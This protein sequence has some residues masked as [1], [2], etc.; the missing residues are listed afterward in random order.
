VKHLL[1]ERL[2]KLAGLLTEQDTDKDIVGPCTNKT[3]FDLSTGTIEAILPEWLEWSASLTNTA[4]NPSFTLQGNAAGAL[5]ISYLTATPMLNDPQSNFLNYFFSLSGEAPTQDDAEASGLPSPLC[6]YGYVSEAIM[7]MVVNKQTQE[8]FVFSNFAELISQLQSTSWAPVL[9]GIGGGSLNNVN[10]IPQLVNAIQT[11]NQNE[12]VNIEFDFPSLTV[13][14]C[15]CVWTEMIYGCTNPDACNYDSEANNFEDG[16]TPDFCDYESCVGC[17]DENANN[18]GGS[19]ITTN[20]YADVPYLGDLAG[21]EVECE[22]P[23]GPDRG[24]D[25]LTPDKDVRP[26]RPDR[27]RPQDPIDLSP[28]DRP[29]PYSDQT[30]T[31]GADL[32]TTGY[33]CTATGQCVEYQFNPEDF[34]P[35]FQAPDAPFATLEECIESGCQDPDLCNDFGQSICNPVCEATFDCQECADNFIQSSGVYNVYTGPDMSPSD[36]GSQGPYGSFGPCSSMAMYT[37]SVM[38]RFKK[39]AN[40]KKKK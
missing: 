29:L 22:Y 27:E 38:D 8:P 7:S 5:V 3:L 21:Q 35:G 13:N 16:E 4:N 15:N 14:M 2:K 36:P 25:Y 31:G 9:F 6:P 19:V 24:P 11:L 37:E 20:V 12:T 17:P 30:Q 40:I 33:M 34:D 23:E 10:N 32:I 26:T 39:L 1:K 28:T 18:Y